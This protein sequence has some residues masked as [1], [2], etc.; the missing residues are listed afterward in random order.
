[1]TPPRIQALTG[2][3]TKADYRIQPKQ[4]STWKRRSFC[5]SNFKHVSGDG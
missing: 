3:A 2:T 1:M 5:A 4:V